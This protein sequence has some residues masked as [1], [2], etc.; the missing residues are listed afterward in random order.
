MYFYQVKIN[1]DFIKRLA[2]ELH[3][4]AFK[5]FCYTLY[6]YART[7]FPGNTRRSIR[8]GRATISSLAENMCVERD[9]RI[10]Y[11]RR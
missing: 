7:D 3:I 11:R 8:R 6:V 4:I 10:N 9:A 1:H 5:P 2:K